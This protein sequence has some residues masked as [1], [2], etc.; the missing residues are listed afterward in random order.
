M[1]PRLEVDMAETPQRWPLKVTV[2]LNQEMP[3][4]LRW[5]LAADKSRKLIK[6]KDNAEVDLLHQETA[7]SQVIS[8]P[9][10]KYMKSSKIHKQL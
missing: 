1:E 10:Q 6:H 3:G 7:I 2:D 8:K 5:K 9:G 4:I